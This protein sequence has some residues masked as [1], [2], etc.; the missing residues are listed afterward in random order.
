[1]LVKLVT[2]LT[3][4]A[5]VGVAANQAANVTFRFQIDESTVYGCGTFTVNF[6]HGKPPYRLTA[7][8]CHLCPSIVHITHPA[9]E[10]QRRVPLGVCAVH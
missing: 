4:G 3:G 9:A 5:W 7:I 10:Q 8:V 1:M 2:I 6:T